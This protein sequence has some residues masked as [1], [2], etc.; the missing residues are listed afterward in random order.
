MSLAFVKNVCI[1][2]VYQLPAG[3]DP[4]ARGVV[5]KQAP[6]QAYGMD[7]DWQD[8]NLGNFHGSKEAAMAAIVEWYED[9]R[10][11]VDGQI[12]KACSAHF[13]Y[14]PGCVMCEAENVEKI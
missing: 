6:W 11:K 10:L 5:Q 7:K 2:R 14:R 3:P 1:G 8:T 12:K 9:R 4:V 13:S